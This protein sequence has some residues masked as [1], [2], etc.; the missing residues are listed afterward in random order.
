LTEWNTAVS[1]A[2]DAALAQRKIA[3]ALE[4]LGISWT[5]EDGGYKDATA[6]EVAVAYVRAALR[7]DEAGDAWAIYSIFKAWVVAKG[8][9]QAQVRFQLGQGGMPADEFNDYHWPAY[10]GLNAFAAQIE[11]YQTVQNGWKNREVV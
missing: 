7:M 5:I 3:N 11:T 9:N 4:A 1:N 8:W 2:P 10:E 6:Q